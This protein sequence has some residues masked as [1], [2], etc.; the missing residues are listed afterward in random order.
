MNYVACE[1]QQFHIHNLVCS[2]TEAIGAGKSIPQNVF[3]DNHTITFSW[4]GLSFYAAH[5]ALEDV[6]MIQ[7]IVSTNAMSSLLL[8]LTC[9]NSQVV[10][11]WQDKQN[12]SLRSAVH[13]ING[14]SPQ[15]I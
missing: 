13:K 14:H 12:G 4:V 3:Q 7:R 2:G 5:W 1:E 8:Q 9:N 10:T 11:Q 6:K 15:V